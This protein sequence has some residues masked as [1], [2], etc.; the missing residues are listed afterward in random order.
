MYQST[1][2]WELGTVFMALSILLGLVSH[3][4][5]QLQLLT[6]FVP[7]LCY[8]FAQDYTDQTAP[9]KDLETFHKEYNLPFENLKD[10]STLVIDFFNKLIK[11]QPNVAD[12]LYVVKTTVD[13]QALKQEYD[14]YR[15]RAEIF[16]KELFNGYTAGNSWL[17]SLRYTVLVRRKFLKN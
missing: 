16:V 10:S 8:R 12:N 3:K 7:L 4:F 14:V 1:N 6:F 17:C 2:T 11:E 15:Y 5:Y 9:K 13:E